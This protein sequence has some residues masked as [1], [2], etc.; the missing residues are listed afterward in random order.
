MIEQRYADLFAQGAQVGIEVAEREV[1]LTYVLKTSR[2]LRIS[3]PSF[4]LLPGIERIPPR[5]ASPKT[6]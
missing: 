5:P 3:A 6:L 1:V 2:L 4:D